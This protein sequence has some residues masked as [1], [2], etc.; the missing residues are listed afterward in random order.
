MKIRFRFDIRRIFRRFKRKK[1][2]ERLVIA[3]LLVILGSMFLC[4]GGKDGEI[5][6]ASGILTAGDI[7]DISSSSRRFDTDIIISID[8]QRYTIDWSFAEKEPRALRNRLKS[9]EGST[10]EYAYLVDSNNTPRI[11]E[12]KI[13]GEE[14]VSFEPTH[15]NIRKD[16]YL[17]II[18]GWLCLMISLMTI[19]FEL[20][21][22]R[23]IPRKKQPRQFASRQKPRGN[24]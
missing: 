19:L 23:L 3:V 11:L 15:S 22:L 7:R 8:H 17:S 18:T 14:Y 4:F 13:N 10:A 20:R 6:Q 16:G 12:L 21:I 24:S 1:T 2:R 9:A 5:R